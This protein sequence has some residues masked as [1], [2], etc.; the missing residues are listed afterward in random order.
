MIYLV[1]LYRLLALALL[2]L[3]SSSFHVSPRMS[4]RSSKAATLYMGSRIDVKSKNWL[5]LPDIWDT[6]A[7]EVPDR[8]MLVDPVHGDRVDVTYSQARDLIRQ[9]AGA[10]QQLG[11]KPGDCV[12]I[13]AENSHRWLIADQA[14]M[15]TGACDAVRGALAP[16]DELQYIYENSHSVGLVVESPVLLQQLWADGVSGLK[17]LS[18]PNG[19]KFIIV[20]YPPAS[21]SS[22][23]NGGSSN[24]VMTG[25][26]IAKTIPNLP[27]TCKV[28]NYD[29]WM[30][31]NS[32]SFVSGQGGFTPVP[33]DNK[34]T[35]TLVYT[36]GTTSKPKGVMLRHSNILHQVVFNTF[37]KTRGN[38]Y[39]PS[40]GDV[41]LSI[42]PCWHIYERT[43]E[44]YCLARGVQ[45]VYSNL[46]NFKSDL[47]TWKP[48]FLFAVPRLFEN[49][50]KGIVSNLRQQSESKKR[51]IAILT[52]ITQLYVRSRRTFFNLL[53]R[54]TK[55]N[56]FQRLSAGLAALLLF[57]LHLIGDKLIWGKIR[58]N[59]GGRM[60]VMASGGSILP[61]HIESF[62]DMVGL[63]IIVGYGLT[64]SSPII[65][66]RF[67]EHNIMGTV[68]LPFDKTSIKIVDPITKK[69]VPR[70]QSGVLLAKGP[71]IMG[72]YNRDAAATAKAIDTEG[73]FDTGDRARLNM[74]TNDY[75]ITGREKDTIV[76]SNGENVEPQPLEDLLVSKSALIDQ[77]LLV[78]QDKR[79]LTALIVVNAQEL[80]RRGLVTPEKGKLLES[81]IGQ[82][83]TTMGP[84]GD[85]NVL[86]RESEL[87]DE[88]AN[89][90]RAFTAEL[91]QITGNRRP[92]ERVSSFK[93]LLEPFSV[94][95]GQL[96]QTLKLKRATVS[97]YYESQVATIYEKK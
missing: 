16:V 41:L 85:I 61:L 1:D 31:L 46:R 54:N 23:S 49:I 28:L 53:V 78:G 65:T 88:D 73:Y 58:Q 82:A 37:S 60:K 75:I 26:E 18:S 38:Y 47:V 83:P 29:E 52:A 21:T 30:A 6:L 95:N 93:L 71:S 2:L 7:A 94:A 72:G 39:D 90:R 12:S 97:S 62:F 48:H 55:P 32:Q 69:E 66:N 3:L 96:T 11:V 80:A 19:P 44:Y 36:S 27:S 56:I 68:G 42:L 57:P 81:I 5:V 59:L 51:L 25:A 92:W 86:R 34:A 15:K 13:F 63:N 10:M 14:I 8:C 33:R 87:L 77:T 91:D 64:E 84:V 79:F 40:V 35:A 76:L 45:M 89:I 9:G 50:H 70:G 24:S 67:V 20:L 43:A 74:A 17:S 4:A 22:G